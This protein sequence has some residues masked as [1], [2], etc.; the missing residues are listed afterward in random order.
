MVQ[1]VF[2]A[3]ADQYSFY[4]NLK[5][6]IKYNQLVR[7]RGGMH[8]PLTKEKIAGRE[9]LLH[10]SKD[11]RALLPMDILSPGSCSTLERSCPRRQSQ[12]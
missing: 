6:L 5:N 2:Y 3:E 8:S 7:S 10:D 11:E 12:R 1:I 4:F 9:K